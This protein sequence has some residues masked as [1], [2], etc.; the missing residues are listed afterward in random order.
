M[1]RQHSVLAAAF[2]VLVLAGAL[3]NWWPAADRT[4]PAGQTQQVDAHVLQQWRFYLTEYPQGF[5]GA[6]QRM[7]Y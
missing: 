4:K 2:G 7:L 5:V 3:W 6:E 1:T